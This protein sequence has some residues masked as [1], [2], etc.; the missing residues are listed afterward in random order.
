M[1]VTRQR[2]RRWCFTWNNPGNANPDQWPIR[3]LRWS[4]ELSESGTL[5]YQG[6][7]VWHQPKSMGAVRKHGPHCHWEVM[8]GTLEQNDTY[9]SKEDTHIDGPWTRGQRPRPGARNDLIDVAA[10]VDAGKSLGKIARAYPAPYMR[11]YAGI[12]DYRLQTSSSRTGDPQIFILWGP[13]GCGKSRLVHEVFPKAYWKPRSS[14]WDGYNCQHVVVLDDFYSWI[15][16]D[17]F[18]RV[19]DRYPLHLEIKGGAV[20]MKANIFV[21]T[22][23]QD[24]MTWYSKMP[25][26]SAMKRRF[27]EY[28]V[29]YCWD[30]VRNKFELDLRFK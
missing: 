20:R 5:H 29:V 13:T 3:Y 18:L 15:K 10:M 19:L 17:T 23:N 30:V 24:P 27:G 22:S 6:Y 7:V 8:R 16:Y 28:G 25:D 12:K 2:S 1:A 21:F 4:L 9:V 26:T 11:Y 14:W